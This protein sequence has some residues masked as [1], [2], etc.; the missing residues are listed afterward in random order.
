VIAARLWF[1]VPVFEDVPA[2]LE[3]RRRLADV[4]AS[5]IDGSIGDHRF[6]VIDDTGGRDP[7]VGQLRAYPDVRAIEAPFNLGHQRAIVYGLRCLTDEIRDE[8]IVVTLDADGEDRPEDLPRLLGPLMAAEGAQ[9]LVLARRTRRRT[10][11]RFKMMYLV[12]RVLFRLLTGTSVRSGNYAAYRGSLA[13]R[14]LLHPHFDLCYSSS[15]LTLNRDILFV[16]CERGERY[17][18]RSKM[19]FARLF[20]HGL[21]MMMPFADRVAMRALILFTV[22]FSLGV[23]LSATVVAVRLFGD[24]TVPGWATSA[25]IGTLLLSFIALGNF[26]TLFAVFS[27]SMSISLADIDRARH[28]SA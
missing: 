28:G 4:L 20:L 14:M 25:I 10:S 2:F 6:V 18:G 21:R 1:V 12:F 17:S 27:Q 11:L 5:S 3:L 24:I 9:R 8:D 7:Q 15:L 22:T 19:G 26:I 23:L 16:P 13:K